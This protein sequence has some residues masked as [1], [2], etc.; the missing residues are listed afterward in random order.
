MHQYASGSAPRYGTFNPYCSPLANKTSWMS[1][2]SFVTR[3]SSFV[4][5]LDYLLSVHSF[6]GTRDQLRDFAS[7]LPVEAAKT[8]KASS[9]GKT[10]EK[11]RKL[12]L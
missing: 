2:R 10:A 5:L 3:W 7:S 12:N 11:I 9:L 8:A 6:T 4:H 1:R